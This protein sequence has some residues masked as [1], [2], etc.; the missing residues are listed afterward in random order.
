MDNVGHIRF[1]IYFADDDWTFSNYLS[2]E[3]L[4]ITRMGVKVLHENCVQTSLHNSV[5]L[6]FSSELYG[7]QV[8]KDYPTRLVGLYRRL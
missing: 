8:Y 6:E 3:D 4:R 5:V 2:H 1:I 7:S